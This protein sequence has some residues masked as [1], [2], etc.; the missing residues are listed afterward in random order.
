MNILGKCLLISHRDILVNNSA[1]KQQLYL[2]FHT[3]KMKYVHKT[4]PQKVYII[5]KVSL[6]VYK[7]ASQIHFVDNLYFDGRA[8]GQPSADYLEH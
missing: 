6:Q 8:K 2:F 1:K 3:M 7:Y 4:G 5:F